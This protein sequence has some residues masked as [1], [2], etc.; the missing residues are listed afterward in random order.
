MEVAAES[1]A[2]EALDWAAVV[3][4]L[5]AA[6]ASVLKMELAM[7]VSELA[8]V[9]TAARRVP[10]AWAGLVAEMLVSAAVAEPAWGAQSSPCMVR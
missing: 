6:V 9:V 7:V 4:V 1:V 2:A 10:M 3:A 8:A 5:A